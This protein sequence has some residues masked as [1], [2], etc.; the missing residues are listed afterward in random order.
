M[1]KILMPACLMGSWTQ[2]YITSNQ[3]TQTIK[4][5]IV[6]LQVPSTIGKLFDSILN[7]KLDSFFKNITLSIVA[8]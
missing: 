6:I 2:E 5:I 3:V 7:Y 8:K 4:I 1:L